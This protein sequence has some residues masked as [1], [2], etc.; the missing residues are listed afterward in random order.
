M[1]NETGLIDAGDSLLLVVDI[2]ERFAAHITNWDGMLNRSKILVQAAEI[3]GIPVLV[4]E[5]YPKGLGHTVDELKECVEDF[6][7]IEKTSFGCFGDTILDEAIGAQKKRTLVLCGIETH[8]CVLQTAL[9]GIRKD[10]RVVLVLDAT[11]SRNESD[12]K[13]ALERMDRAAVTFVSTEMILM[14][15]LGDAKN[16]NFKAVQGLIK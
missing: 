8:V 2:Q 10:Y 7:P 9:E 3:L 11:S 4:S 5:Q 15:W 12:M 13:I 16:A 6:D 14:E 1:N